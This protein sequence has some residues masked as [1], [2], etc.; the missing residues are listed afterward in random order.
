MDVAPADS[1]RRSLRLSNNTDT[2]IPQWKKET[3]TTTKL[4]AVAPRRRSGRLSLASKQVPKIAPTEV[5][6]QQHSVAGRNGRI[7]DRRAKQKPT[8]KRTA[9]SL[10]EGTTAAA[11]WNGDGKSV[12]HRRGKS[13]RRVRSEPPPSSSPAKRV[14]RLFSSTT[15]NNNSSANCSAGSD[16]PQQ[17]MCEMEGLPQEHHNLVLTNFQPTKYTSGLSFFDTHHRGDVLQSPEYVSDIFQ[18][19]YQS[20]VRDG[21]GTLLTTIAAAAERLLD[22]MGLLLKSFST[23]LIMFFIPFSHSRATFSIATF[24]NKKTSPRICV[25]SSS[26]GWS[27]FT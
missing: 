22:V 16:N 17:Q 27:K 18:R 9:T 6:R 20:E 7:A 11:A 1:N 14:R 10:D 3:A 21:D 4:A 15:T 19:L 8:F 12:S 24:I 25:L 26:I 13:D 2:N 23:F 5:V